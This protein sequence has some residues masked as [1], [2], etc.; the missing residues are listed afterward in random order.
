MSNTKN[1]SRTEILAIIDAYDGMLRQGGMFAPLDRNLLERR[2]YW[3]CE[4]A[5][6]GGR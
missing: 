2:M 1:P 6:L 5:K 3:V 4:L